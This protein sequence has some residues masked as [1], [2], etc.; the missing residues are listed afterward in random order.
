MLF[1]KQ[2]GTL[3]PIEADFQTNIFYSKT[4]PEVFDFF[5]QNKEVPYASLSGLREIVDS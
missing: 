1:L 5:R 2:L 3:G 4:P